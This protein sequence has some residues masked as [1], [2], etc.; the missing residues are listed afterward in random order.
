MVG[1]APQ[2]AFHRR[3][4]KIDLGE[5]PLLQRNGWPAKTSC[6]IFAGEPAT[7]SSAVTSCW[8]R[9]F[10]R[11]VKVAGVLGWRNIVNSNNADAGG[12]LDTSKLIQRDDYS[13]R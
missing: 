13:D 9:P 6:R 2:R 8:G 1:R 12:T 4:V 5:E 11:R 10:G 3:N 7:A